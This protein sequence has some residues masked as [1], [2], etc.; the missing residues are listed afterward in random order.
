MIGVFH[1]L[2]WQR[3]NVCL[4]GLRAQLSTLRSQ[5]ATQYQCNRNTTYKPDD[6]NGQ[7]KHVYIP[8]YFTQ[9]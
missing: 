9:D 6:Q 7:W 3:M 5:Q 8:Q 2:S 1:T 4:D